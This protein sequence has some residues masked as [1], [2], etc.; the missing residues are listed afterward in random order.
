[1][2]AQRIDRARMRTIRFYSDHVSDAPVLDWADEAVC[3]QRARAAAGAGRGS[4]GWPIV[5]WER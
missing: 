4:R 5:D 2:A 1:M 3:G